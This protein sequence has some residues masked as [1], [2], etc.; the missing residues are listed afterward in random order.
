M[1]STEMLSN[2]VTELTHHPVEKN[3]TKSRLAEDLDIIDALLGSMSSGP[4]GN[5]HSAEIQVMPF[6]HFDFS[7]P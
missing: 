6:C 3:A 1:L 7:S 4:G 2:I 5:K